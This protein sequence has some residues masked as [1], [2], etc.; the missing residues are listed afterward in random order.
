MKAK[1]IEALGVSEEIAS[2]IVEM[3]HE[4]ISGRY[5]PKERMDEINEAKKNAE[6]L[7]KERDKQLEELKK[8][9]GDSESLKEEIAKLQE[10]N[11][12][13][14]KEYED[15]INRMKLD[16]AVEKAINDVKGKNVKA[17]R[18]LLNLDNAKLAE[19]GTVEGVADQLKALIESEDTSFLFGS[20]IPDVAGFVPDA[21]GVDPQ[22]IDFS[23]MSYSEISDYMA[24]NPGAKIS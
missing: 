8:S 1:E 13:A 11:K 14:K 7:I 15:N 6:A 19:D 16:G 10:A 20:Q 22:A 12:T 3:V 23:K 18:A 2:K 5:V 17:I 21:G 9:V 24:K 4:E